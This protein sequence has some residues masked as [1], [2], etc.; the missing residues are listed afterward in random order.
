MLP[1][2]SDIIKK[3]NELNEYNLL[4]QAQKEALEKEL[5]LYK[6]INMSNMTINICDI[7]TKDILNVVL[8]FVPS[9]I[10]FLK[11]PVNL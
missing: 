2:V 5:T 4:L 8:S 3:L 10:Q 1:N 11:T 7:V 6:D 9:Y